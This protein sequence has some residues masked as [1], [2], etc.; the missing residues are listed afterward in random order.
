MNDFLT[1]GVR[2]L[3]SRFQGLK[4]LDTSRQLFS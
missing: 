4:S 3:S 1:L 2:V